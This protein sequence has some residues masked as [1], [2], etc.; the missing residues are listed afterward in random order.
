MWGH[1]DLL[2]HGSTERPV[3]QAICITFPMYNRCT[4]DS[5]IDSLIDERKND[6]MTDYDVS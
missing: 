1:P 6:R 5:M 4:I 3:G 2:D